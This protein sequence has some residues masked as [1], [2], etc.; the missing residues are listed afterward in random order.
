MER[1]S[2]SASAGSASRRAV[3]ASPSCV[4]LLHMAAN[5]GE[6]LDRVTLWAGVYD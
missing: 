6:P 3:C 5:T 2:S 4:P 1:S